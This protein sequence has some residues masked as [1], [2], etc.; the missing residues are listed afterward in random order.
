[1]KILLLGKNGQLGW[2][3]QRCLAPLGDIF[4]I[5]YPEVD[6]KESQKVHK[7]VRKISPDVII[8]AAAYTSV[9]DAEE[10]KDLAMT[11][12]GTGPGI[13]A[14][15]A[16]SLGA[17]LVHYSTDYVF[18][19]T[20]KEAYIESD[21]PDPINVY[22]WSKLAGEQNVQQ[23]GG[24][25]LIF[26]TSWLYSLRSGGF[27]RKVLGWARTNETL[28]IVSD[29]V[30]SPTWV[31][32]L[33]EATVQVLARAGEKPLGWISD[34]SGLYHLGG[35]GVV[36]RLDWAK[37]VLKYDPNSGEQVVRKILPAKTSEFPTPAKRPFYTP[38][39]CDLFAITF[40]LRLPNWEEALRMAMV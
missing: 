13:L 35:E 18:D 7:L 37:A 2:E 11:V 8:N 27:V 34:R 17:A 15:E 16:R 9:D 32:M 20:K 29:Q 21:P 19:G 3:L 23:V 24:A 12:N 6:L 33:A 10:E 40:G 39:N 25:Y 1:M 5:D 26:R 14:E 28:R 4:S 38:L 31:R 30:G 36:S 22:G